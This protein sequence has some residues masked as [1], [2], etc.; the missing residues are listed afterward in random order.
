MTREVLKRNV[1]GALYVNF[2]NSIY[3][4]DLKN[5]EVKM[6][7]NYFEYFKN[8]SNNLNLASKYRIVEF[9][10]LT[11]KDIKKIKIIANNILNID[12]EENGYVK[13]NEILI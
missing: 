1:I 10:K 8:N 13:I 4:F 9:L 6:N 3:S 11:E 5:E 12:L 7:K 2:D